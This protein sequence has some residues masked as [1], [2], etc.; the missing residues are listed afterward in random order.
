MGLIIHRFCL[1]SDLVY[2]TRRG[3]YV[4]RNFTWSQKWFVSNNF[5]SRIVCSFLLYPVPLKTI[6]ITPCKLLWMHSSIKR[7]IYLMVTKSNT[8]MTVYHHQVNKQ[9]SFPNFDITFDRFITTHTYEKHIFIRK[10]EFYKRSFTG[11]GYKKL[12][13]R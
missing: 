1:F 6:E 3:W 8:L 7:E 10:P 2:S 9:N 11:G 13:N 12:C 5:L 4:F